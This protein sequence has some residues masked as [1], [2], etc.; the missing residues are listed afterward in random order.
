MRMQ[1]WLIN[2]QAGLF[3]NS[4]AA[5]N[6]NYNDVIMKGVKSNCT[7]VNN[8]ASV[9]VRACVVRRRML[10]VRQYSTTIIPGLYISFRHE[11]GI[12]YEWQNFNWNAIALQF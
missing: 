7:L 2:K 4:H 1:F 3:S 9:C 10:Y 11:Y 12:R 5:C 6:E 8:F